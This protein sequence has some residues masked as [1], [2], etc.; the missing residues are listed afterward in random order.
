MCRPRRRT[1]LGASL[2]K[3]QKEMAAAAELSQQDWSRIEREGWVPPDNEL[4]R[5]CRAIDKPVSEA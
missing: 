4:V 3:T 5:L 1:P 2:G